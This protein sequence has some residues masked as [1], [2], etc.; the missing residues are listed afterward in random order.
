M[1]RGAHHPAIRDADVLPR[2][3]KPR[4]RMGEAEGEDELFKGTQIPGSGVRQPLE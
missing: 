2:L 1:Q 3:H 4:E